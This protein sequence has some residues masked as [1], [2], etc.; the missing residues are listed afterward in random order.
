MENDDNV[1]DCAN[2]QLEDYDIGDAHEKRR[3][4]ED[5]LKVLGF[6]QKS[7]HCDAADA[8]GDHVHCA[9]VAC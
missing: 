1:G 5:D 9:D 8:N 4:E 2:G 6:G 7:W 3:H